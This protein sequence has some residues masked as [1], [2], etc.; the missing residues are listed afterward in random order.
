M[1]QKKT[2]FILFF[3]FFGCLTFFIGHRIKKENNYHSFLKK[4]IEENK[5]ERKRKKTF[6]SLLKDLE[7][8]SKIKF[9]STIIIVALGLGFF[10]IKKKK[11]KQR[12]LDKAR[13]PF[14][15]WRC[16]LG[17]EIKKNVLIGVNINFKN[18]EV[19]NKEVNKIKSHAFVSNNFFLSRANSKILCNDASASLL[20]ENFLNNKQYLEH[21][22]FLAGKFLANITVS[23][24]KEFSS[25]RDDILSTMS[26]KLNNQLL[27]KSVKRQPSFTVF[28]QEFENNL[29]N[30]V[31]M[32]NQEKKLYDQNQSWSLFRSLIKKDKLTY[33][34][35]NNKTIVFFDGYFT[36]YHLVEMIN[37]HL[38]KFFQ[39]SANRQKFPTIFKNYRQDKEN[40]DNFLNL[41]KPQII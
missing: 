8:N 31:K 10:S 34:K 1:K 25:S 18:E 29:L 6:F 4:E 19:K 2:L 21:F 16:Y 27:K 36:I 28:I 11:N 15:S 24:L 14:L 17:L 40:L 3:L 39:V 41:S 37:R 20:T 30:M 13:T 32:N 7:K 23:F 5:E 35:K 9:L 22:L 38:N 33:L 12:E 26:K